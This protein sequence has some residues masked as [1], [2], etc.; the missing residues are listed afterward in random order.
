MHSVA[1]RKLL[2]EI[3]TPLYHKV[4]LLEAKETCCFTCCGAGS[5]G[6]HWLGVEA[7]PARRACAVRHETLKTWV[8]PTLQRPTRPTIPSRTTLRGLMVRTGLAHT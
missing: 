6:E 4:A 7:R 3:H 5:L 8:M 1:I 2:D